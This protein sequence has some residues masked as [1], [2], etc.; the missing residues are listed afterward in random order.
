MGEQKTLGRPQDYCGDKD[1]GRV[2]PGQHP[3]TQAGHTP[4]LGQWLWDLG[5]GHSVLPK[6]SPRDRDWRVRVTPSWSQ[7]PG[8]PWAGVG[9]LQP[10]LPGLP[11]SLSHAGS[12]TLLNSTGL[13]TSIRS[14]NSFWIL[15]KRL[16]SI[17]ALDWGRQGIRACSAPSPSFVPVPW[18]SPG[19][20]D[21]GV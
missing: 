1:K 10:T 12:R 16:V 17:G 3:E 6:N 11:G 13:N 9:L 4:R 2:I 20:P 15:L 7:S 5:A 21:L 18:G 19:Q 14:E 8:A